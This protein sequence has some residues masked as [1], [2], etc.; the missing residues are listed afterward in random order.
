MLLI[1]L[2]FLATIYFPRT[3]LS[4]LKHRK[5]SFEPGPAPFSY[6]IDSWKPQYL[7]KTDTVSEST[8][9][10]NTKSKLSFSYELANLSSNNKTDS[11]NEKNI[12]NTKS[13]PVYD[14]KSV[15]VYE[16]AVADQTFLAKQV[17]QHCIV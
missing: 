9:S 6:L 17:I 15:S 11:I 2:G 14:T 13:V 3:D 4:S 10:E 12:T 7:Q 8:V 16:L 5:K 1:L